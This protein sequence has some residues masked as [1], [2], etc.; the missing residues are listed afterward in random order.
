MKYLKHLKD[1]AHGKHLKNI[2][3]NIKFTHAIVQ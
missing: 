3:N 2:S 1:I